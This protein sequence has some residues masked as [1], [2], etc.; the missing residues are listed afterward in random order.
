LNSGD[1]VSDVFGKLGQKVGHGLVKA[2]TAFLHR[3]RDQKGGELFG[4]RADHESGL[5]GVGDVPLHVGQPV[6]F[7]QHDPALIGHQNRAHE[8]LAGRIIMDQFVDPG[9]KG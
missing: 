9:T 2:E 7:G 6:A 1:P 4:D 8:I 3:L 5:G